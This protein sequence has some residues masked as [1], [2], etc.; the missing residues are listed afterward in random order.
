MNVRHF[1]GLWLLIFFLPQGIVSAQTLVFP[2]PT[3]FVN[4]FAGILSIQ[5][6]TE[7]ETALGQFEKET[8]N[9]IVIVIVPNLQEA[10]VE[11]FSVRLFEKWKIGKKGNDNGLLILISMEERKSRIETGYGL[12][13][14]ITDGLAGE[15]LDTQLIPHFRSG[16]YADGLRN[17]ASFI[18]KKI[19]GEEVPDIS[20]KPERNAQAIFGNL[21][22]FGFYLIPL[23]LAWFASFLGRSK[24]IWPGGALGAIA[25]AGIGYLIVQALAFA[26]GGFAIFG[27]LGLL[28]DHIVSKNYQERK[29]RGLPTDFWHSG[30]GF[31]LGGGRG[32]GLGGGFGGFGGGGSG[33]GG[34]SR[35][36]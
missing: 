11:D 5:E 36:W 8:G 21:L 20:Y 23:I 26:I 6:R 27:L 35:G 17:S 15:I 29:R 7:F 16:A 31:F 14:V 3:G 9:E 22:F 12:E 1:L 33:G 24:R 34:A 19:R 30:G 25:G 4:D 28:F 13:P 18:M 32:G 2:K 10:T